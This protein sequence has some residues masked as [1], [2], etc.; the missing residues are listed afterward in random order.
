MIQEIHQKKRE[1]SL[2]DT[3]IIQ[4]QINFHDLEDMIED[5]I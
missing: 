3:Q 1:M 5:E 2:I 4:S